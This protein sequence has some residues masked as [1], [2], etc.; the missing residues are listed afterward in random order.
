MDPKFQVSNNLNVIIK[1]W[2][3]GSGEL[4]VYLPTK[5]KENLLQCKIPRVLILVRELYEHGNKK[6]LLN[7][8]SD[9]QVPP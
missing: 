4:E 8:C 2:D 3:T 6:T 9:K 7:E 5:S 1:D